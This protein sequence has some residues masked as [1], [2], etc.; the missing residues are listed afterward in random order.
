M[1]SGP[2][3]RGAASDDLRG[4]VFLQPLCLCGV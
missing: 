2:Y 3:V 4:D 1:M